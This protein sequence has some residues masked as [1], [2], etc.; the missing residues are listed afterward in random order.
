MSFNWCDYF[1]RL[2]GICDAILKDSLCVLDG[3][4]IV[5][6]GFNITC[7][8]ATIF[9]YYIYRT[10]DWHS[11]CDA[12]NECK[13]SEVSECR[14]AMPSQVAFQQNGA[15]YE[16][17]Q[18]RSMK[19]AFHAA[20]LASPERY[21]FFHSQFAHMVTVLPHFAQ[22]MIKRFD[23]KPQPYVQQPQY[24]RHTQYDFRK[25]NYVLDTWGKQHWYSFNFVLQF[26]NIF[27]NF[28]FSSVGIFTLYRY[29]HSKFQLLVLDQRQTFADN[30]WIINYC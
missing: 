14:N 17:S 10:S 18:C 9:I 20:L 19:A 8:F 5:D 26:L 1:T 7:N 4:S 12:A 11:S 21:P 13:A 3:F 22:V 2:W 30:S 27:S 25:S 24:Y 23:F 29:I 6:L 15:L 28:I 16:P